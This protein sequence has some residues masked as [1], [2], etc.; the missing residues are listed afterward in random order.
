M[1]ETERLYYIDPRAVTASAKVL[2]IRH[3]AKGPE[4]ILDRTIFYPEGG[5]QPCDLG[6][7][8][9]V[10]VEHVGEEDRVV[11][12][13]LKEVPSFVEGDTVAL[14]IDA[15]RRRDHTLQHSGQHLLSAILEREFGLHTLSFHLGTHYSTI[16]I[17]SPALSP[18]QIETIESISDEFIIKDVPV[19]VHCC[20][21]EDQAAF[22]LRKMPPE[23]EEVLRIVEIGGYDWVPCC[24]THA[25]STGVLRM[26][27]IFSAEKY[28][29][30]TRIY[31][32]AGDR[33]IKIMRSHHAFL[34]AIAGTLGTSPE[35]APERVVALLARAEKSE[36]DRN[37]LIRKLAVHEVEQKLRARKPDAPAGPLEFFYADRDAD[38]ACETAKEG[39]SQGFAVIAISLPDRAVCVMVPTAADGA[40]GAPRQAKNLGA[41]LKPLLQEYGGRGGGGSGNFRAVFGS[42]DS[43]SAFA[44]KVSVVLRSL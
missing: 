22:P 13:V 26:L 1:S 29:G 44:L 17:S 35:E 28:K 14:A 5:G 32:A 31:F 9:G 6:S 33:A 11:L 25:A 24:G 38:A 2:E 41:L 4:I 39:V 23:G 3:S 30:A 42:A 27:K 40:Y 15:A 19:T 36:D 16:D 10:P 34:K 8:D 21:P 12:H 20:P 7:I 43:A 37:A 18:E